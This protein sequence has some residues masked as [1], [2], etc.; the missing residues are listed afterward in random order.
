MLPCISGMLLFSQPRGVNSGFAEQCQG[1]PWGTFPPP[2]AGPTL[3]KTKAQLIAGNIT[4]TLAYN[5]ASD[6]ARA[7]SLLPSK[8]G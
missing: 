7:D 8:S 2:N 3:I 5:T 4:H 6:R 1:F